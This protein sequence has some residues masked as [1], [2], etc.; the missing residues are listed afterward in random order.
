MPWKIYVEVESKDEDHHHEDEQSQLLSEKGAE[1]APLRAN[2]VKQ[3]QQSQ[4]KLLAVKGNELR[5]AAHGKNRLIFFS[6]KFKQF[7]HILDNS[8][9]LLT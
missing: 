3:P 1:Q 8:A 9:A 7:L 4:R 6:N 5:T 2:E